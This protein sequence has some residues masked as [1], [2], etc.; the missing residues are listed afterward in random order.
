MADGLNNQERALAWLAAWNPSFAGVAIV[1]P[2]FSFRSAN[3]Q[4]C[5]ILGV[6]PAELINNKFSD[7]T[8]E[9]IRSLDV[10]NANLIKERVIESYVLPK[11]YEF[12]TGRK[13][14]AVLLVKGVYHPKTSKFLFF[15]S[16]IM[17]KDKHL[18]AE[19]ISHQPTGLLEWME[20]NKG[21]IT[22]IAGGM[23]GFLAWLFGG[24]D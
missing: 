10:K 9:P 21:P 5:D 6:T 16:R 22:V 3:Q 7:I 13:V 11:T 23:T 2:D 19:S 1:N 24:R 15:V 4:F 14:E 17:E 8:P 18:T 20:K 12:P